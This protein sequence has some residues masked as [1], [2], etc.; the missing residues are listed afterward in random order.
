MDISKQSECAIA[1]R[2]HYIDL[3]DIAPLL[4]IDNNEMMDCATLF[5]QL[6]VPRKANLPLW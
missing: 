1:S 5:A 2:L 3:V 4:R 6:T